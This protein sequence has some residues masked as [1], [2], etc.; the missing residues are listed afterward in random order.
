[1]KQDSATIAALPKKTFS[2]KNAFKPKIMSDVLQTDLAR[3]LSNDFNC[4]NF[5]VDRGEH[6]L[7]KVWPACLHR[8]PLGSN[9]QL[10]PPVLVT[11]PDILPSV[12]AVSRPT[13]SKDKI[14]EAASP[15][16]SPIEITADAECRETKKRTSNTQ[17]IS[18]AT[19]DFA[20]STAWSWGRVQINDAS[21]VKIR[22]SQNYVSRIYAVSVR[23]FFERIPTIIGK[24]KRSKAVVLSCKMDQLKSHVSHSMHSSSRAGAGNIISAI[25][26]V[27]AGCRVL[28]R[29]W[30]SLHNWLV[31]HLFIIVG[32]V[33][34]RVYDNR[35]P[36]VHE[37]ERA[38][39]N[40]HEDQAPT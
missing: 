12:N 38:H 13:A 14:S 6:E 33:E 24:I 4:N 22:D 29:W 34:S 23:E 10:C 5:G 39:A 1:M 36:D 17:Y 31:H 37:H 8:T 20:S 35:S 16:I 25:V 27:Q 21:W 30:G 9:K 3:E 18:I 32:R 2:L 19:S 28:C 15:W 7:Y 11:T 40:E 26:V